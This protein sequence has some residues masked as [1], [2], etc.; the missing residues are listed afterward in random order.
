MYVC[1]CVCVCVCM[2]VYIYVWASYIGNHMFTSMYI[3]LSASL[4]V[5]EEMPYYEY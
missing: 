2:Y 1:V 5:H 3:C 4:N